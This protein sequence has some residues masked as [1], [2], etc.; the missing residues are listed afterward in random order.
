MPLTLIYIT[1][2]FTTKDFNTYLSCKMSL[3]K[4]K[5]KDIM[6]AKYARNWK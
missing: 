6:A 3:P 5:Y 2:Q 1:S 4:H